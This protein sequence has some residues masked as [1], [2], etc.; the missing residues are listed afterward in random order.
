M[1]SGLRPAIQLLTCE[2]GASVPRTAALAER[3]QK[4]KFRPPRNTLKVTRAES[5]S[6]GK[7]AKA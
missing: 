2:T 4:W 7:P 1:L 5:F 6:V 3:A